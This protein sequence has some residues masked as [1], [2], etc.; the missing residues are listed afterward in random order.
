MYINSNFLENAMMIQNLF[1]FVL[2]LLFL[3]G[4]VMLVVLWWNHFVTLV[5][6]GIPL[7]LALIGVVFM[8]LGLEK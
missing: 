6:G 7:V 3:V 2:G 4:A 5:L 8:L 1:K